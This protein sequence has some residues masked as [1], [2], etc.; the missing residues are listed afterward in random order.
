MTSLWNLYIADFNAAIISPPVALNIII[1]IMLMFVLL[2][3]FIFTFTIF[4]SRIS[5]GLFPTSFSTI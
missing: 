5:L 2:R 3:R 1:I 4:Q